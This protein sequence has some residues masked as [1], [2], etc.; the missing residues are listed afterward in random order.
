MFK[1]LLLGALLLSLVGCNH[2]YAFNSIIKPP[3]YPGS[4]ADIMYVMDISCSMNDDIYTNYGLANTTDEFANLDVSWQLAVTSADPDDEVWVET[5]P[6]G[7]PGWETVVALDEIQSWDYYSGHA[8]AGIASAIQKM[9]DHEEWFRPNATS[10]VVLVSDEEEQS[11]VDPP[12]IFTVWP[13]DLIVVGI[14]GPPHEPRIEGC[15]ADPAPRYHQV[16]DIYI[17]ICL[18]EPWS[19]VDQLEEIQL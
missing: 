16:L 6:L 8:E 1:K 4:E 9:K 15:S 10:V 13:N 18:E 17:D 19:I 3:I 2:D 7:D 12:E 14:V 11:E 5:D